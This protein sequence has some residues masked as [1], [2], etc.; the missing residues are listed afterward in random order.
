MSA[1]PAIKRT[2][3]AY[4]GARISQMNEALA[5]SRWFRINATAK[6]H[7]PSDATVNTPL[8]DTDALTLLSQKDEIPTPAPQPTT[9][10]IKVEP[11]KV[12]PI[13]IQQVGQLGPVQAPTPTPV[14][15]APPAPASSS[16]QQYWPLIALI[17]GPAL[18]A[19]VTAA[20]IWGI[21]SDTVSGK[22]YESPLQWLEDQGEHLPQAENQK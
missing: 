19:C 16:W 4:L 7:L 8:T 1:D 22:P 14:I 3:L 21:K 12:E 2:L 10:P 11:I 17:G 13:S 5:L 15:S 9:Q 18:A 6:R 20:T